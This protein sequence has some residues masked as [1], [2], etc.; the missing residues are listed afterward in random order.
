MKSE[1]ETNGVAESK[2]VHPRSPVRSFRT[3]GSARGAPDD[4]RPYLN[5]QKMK[6]PIPIFCAVILALLGSADANPIAIN[7]E[8]IIEKAWERCLVYMDGSTARVS[9][10][11]GYVTEKRATADLYFTV[12]VYWPAG[13][14]VDLERAAQVIAPRI[15]CDGTVYMP[16]SVRLASDVLPP[17]DD[18]PPLDRV[19]IDCD[20]LIKF[21][22]GN[23]FSFVA[24]YNQPLISGTA[25]YLPLFERDPTPEKAKR[26]TITFFPSGFGELELLS[27]HEDRAKALR[28]RVTITPKHR[29][30][31][32]VRIKQGEQGATGQPATPPR[33]GD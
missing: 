17:L 26:F 23:G 3:P 7:G 15:E 6:G 33:V 22:K 9:C 14:S 24:S 19:K 21:P 2:R 31:I 27:K 32:A 13:E 8:S 29:E 10:A 11:V 25:Y 28:T 18:D 1:T 12:P 5:R 16:T 4:R 20:F 30:L